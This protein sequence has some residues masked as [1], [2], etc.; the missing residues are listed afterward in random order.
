MEMNNE[1]NWVDDRLAVLEPAWRANMARGSELLDAGLRRRVPFRLWIPAAAA[2]AVC[3]AVALPQTRAV[4][5]QL[6]NHFALNRVEVVR[7]DFSKLPL[8]VEMPRYGT[9]HKVGDLAAAERVA[10]FQ[11]FVPAAGVPPGQP[12]IG[13]LSLTDL[14][15]VVHV[16][17]LRDALKKAGVDDVTVPAKWEGVRL[18]YHIGPIVSL[19][20][21]GDVQIQQTQPLEFSVPNGFPLQRF[22]EV[23]FRCTGLSA[24]E[25][26]DMARKFTANPAW[27][28]DAPP[29][30]AALLHADIEQIVLRSGPALLMQV[31]LGDANRS[32]VMIVRSAP[33]RIFVVSTSNR[34][35]ALEIGDELS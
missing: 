8:G 20:Y 34:Q 27:F 25:A 15:Q 32:R 19:L 26:A 2:A 9:S 4:A 14:T 22:A 5:Q 24:R 35:Q 30:T 11:P 17:A 29:E 18:N 13:V 31:F 1:M 10:G 23:A 28:L 21:P 12:S 16:A 7:V 33:D 3:I 6:W